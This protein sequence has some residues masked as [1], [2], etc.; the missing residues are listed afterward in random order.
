MNGWPR[1]SSGLVLGIF[2]QRF[3][4]SFQTLILSG[5]EGLLRDWRASGWGQHGSS[6]PKVVLI[7]TAPI[8]S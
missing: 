3:S 1:V 8:P 2:T 4:V 5:M 6:S 7:L